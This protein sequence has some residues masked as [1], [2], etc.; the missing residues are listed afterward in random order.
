MMKKSLLFISLA[1]IFITCGRTDDTKRLKSYLST[2]GYDICKFRIVCFIPVDG[3]VSCIN[4]FLDYS[5]NHYDC[6]L[7]VLYSIYE[8]SI[9]HTIAA[10]G[11]DSKRVLS[12]AKNEAI[13]HGLGDFTYP[14][15][16]F[17]KDGSDTREENT[18]TVPDKAV[19]F[20]EMNRFLITANALI[21][22]R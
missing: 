2:W 7:L 21:V 3:C 8:K 17:I 14:V 16:Y 15:V 20:S 5:K 18:S 11:L 13:K 1:T 19:L 6:Y 9:S 10:K 4:P 22:G 12:D